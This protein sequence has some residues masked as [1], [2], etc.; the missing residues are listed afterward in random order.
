MVRIKTFV[1]PHNDS[2]ARQSAY[3][4]RQKLFESFPLISHKADILLHRCD[5]CFIVRLNTFVALHNDS[6][7][8]QRLSA[9][10]FALYCD[11]NFYV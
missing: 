4:A 3:V 7:A 6:V 10:S 11:A 5:N 2:V 8:R 9:N 1:A